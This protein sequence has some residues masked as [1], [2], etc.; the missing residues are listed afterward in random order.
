[1]GHEKPTED[2]RELAA[3][4]SLGT[5]TQHEA[6]S[7]K[8]HLRE[9]CPICKAELLEFMHITAEIGLAADEAEAPAHIRRVLLDRVGHEAPSRKPLVKTEPAPAEPAAAPAPRPILTQAPAS[10]TP[11]LPW[12]LVGLFAV[13]AA[14]AFAAYR[15]QQSANVRAK[16]D[17][18]VLEE[19]LRNLQSSYDKE[20]EKQGALEQIISAASRPDTRIMR[21][22]GLNTALSSSGAVIWDFKSK[23]CLVF[24]YLPP[25]APGKAYQL[26]YMTPLAKVPSG[27]LTQNPS[28]YFYE[29]FQVPQDITSATMVITLE[30]EGGS[31]QPTA[32]YYAISRND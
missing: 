17:I 30:P 8:T 27:T 5:L 7:F 6:E 25:A 2:I 12:I 19:D 29:W 13:L 10:R 31:N 14:I 28:G 1:M 15:S 4:Y 23:K 20:K 3:L 22:K 24:G 21:M 32:P 11:V 16:S 9:G 26:W 18:N